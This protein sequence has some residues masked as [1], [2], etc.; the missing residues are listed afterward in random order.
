MV[1]DTKI[2]RDSHGDHRPASTLYGEVFSQHSVL[3]ES[4][5]RGQCRFTVISESLSTNNHIRVETGGGGG[6]RGR[7]VGRGG[8]TVQNNPSVLILAVCRARARG[9]LLKAL[10]ELPLNNGSLQGA[11]LVAEWSGAFCGIPRGVLSAALVREHYMFTTGHKLFILSLMAMF[12]YLVLRLSIKRI[13]FPAQRV[14]KIEAFF[15]SP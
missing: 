2:K 13:L 5:G 14:A 6:R 11:L 12:N 4:Q 15:F 8:G 1:R 10:Q 3:S 9:I 7:A